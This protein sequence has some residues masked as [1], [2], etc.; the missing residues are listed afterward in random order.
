VTSIRVTA[1]HCC[2]DE[3]N[4]S[5][6]VWVDKR[7]EDQPGL[8]MSRSLG[9]TIVHKSGV[10]AELEISERMIDEFDDFFILATLCTTTTLFKLFIRL[11][12]MLYVDMR[13]VDGRYCLQ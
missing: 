13:E 8:A 9:G 3:R 10:S 7:L 6:L 2:L 11:S 1:G 5:T 12:Q 4:I